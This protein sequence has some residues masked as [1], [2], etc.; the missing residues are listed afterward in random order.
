MVQLGSKVKLALF[1]TKNGCGWGVKTKQKIK[2]GTFVM[3]YLGEV[4]QSSS[5]IEL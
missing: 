1:K 5:Q 2:K 4:C 3:E